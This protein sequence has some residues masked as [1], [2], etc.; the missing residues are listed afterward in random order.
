M[1][2]QQRVFPGYSSPPCDIPH[3]DEQRITHTRALQCRDAALEQALV[4]MY[5]GGCKANFICVVVAGFENTV[6]YV[7]QFFVVAEQFENRLMAGAGQA[8]AEYV[9]R[10]RVECLDQ[11]V[12]IDNDD[13]CVKRVKYIF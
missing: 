2:D 5:L 4:C 8:N 3:L 1:L 6:Q 12:A 9:F 13:G 7:S 11:Q 10:C